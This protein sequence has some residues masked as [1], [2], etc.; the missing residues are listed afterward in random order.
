MIRRAV[1]S[2]DA[3]TIKFADAAIEAYAR[4]GDDAL[5]AAS[6]RAT[7]QIAA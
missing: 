2:G 1:D 4:C 6:V 5:L 7:E 3:H